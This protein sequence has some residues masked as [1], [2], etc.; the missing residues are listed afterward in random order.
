MIIKI[1]DYMTQKTGSPIDGIIISKWA[2]G[3]ILNW[4]DEEKLEKL[5]KEYG[6][7]NLEYL[8]MEIIKENPNFYIIKNKKI[9]DIE[10]LSKS[11]CE[12][13]QNIKKYK[14]DKRITGN[15]GYFID[16]FARENPI[17]IPV[18]IKE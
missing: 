5:Y 4:K 3:H 10:T 8:E 11:F 7:K 13:L 2:Y 9:K 17:I 14:K 15:V 1:F 12:D 6:D 16:Y 18:I